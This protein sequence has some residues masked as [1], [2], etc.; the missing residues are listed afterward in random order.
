LKKKAQ[1]KNQL[2]NLFQMMLGRNNNLRWLWH[3]DKWLKLKHKW[4][5]KHFVDI[6]KYGKS[7]WSQYYKRYKHKIKQKQ[8]RK[9]LSADKKIWLWL[10]SLVRM[11]KIEYNSLLTYWNHY[12]L[13]EQIHL[14]PWITKIKLNPVWGGNISGVYNVRKKRKKKNISL[15]FEVIK[16]QLISPLGKTVESEKQ[17]QSKH[18]IKLT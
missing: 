1:G 7:N 15:N 16:N 18:W 8:L 14:Y 9:G 6:E 2:L 5:C 10:L 17:K 13:K 3:H 4:K 11:K 12:R